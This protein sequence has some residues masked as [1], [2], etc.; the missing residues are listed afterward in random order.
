MDE[1]TLGYYVLNSYAI[2]VSIACD[3]ELRAC[4]APRKEQISIWTGSGISAI[5]TKLQLIDW[6]GIRGAA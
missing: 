3:F 1:C 5:E 4:I 2:N 6:A